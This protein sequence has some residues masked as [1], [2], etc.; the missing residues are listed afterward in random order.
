MLATLLTYYAIMN[1]PVSCLFECNTEEDG[2]VSTPNIS[3][4]YFIA[5]MAAQLRTNSPLPTLMTTVA[6][7]TYV[8]TI[9]SVLESQRDCSGS[10]VALEYCY[11]ARNSHFKEEKDLFYYLSLTRDGGSFRVNNKFLI[12]LTSSED[13]DCTDDLSGA[14]GRIC[15][16]RYTLQPSNIIDITS[17]S[18][19]FGV[20][21]RDL[22]LLA[23]TTTATDYNYPQYQMSL[24]GNGPSVG[25]TF[26]IGAPLTA[27][28]LLLLKFILCLKKS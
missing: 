19:S 9:P 1:V 24:G 4:P 17:S 25:G 8:F 7:L 21:V 2:L 23:F 27:R 10:A 18:Y 3:D 22:R 12:E 11:E 5:P 26:G 6:G 14:V 16:G 28:S 13:S 15:C 20:V